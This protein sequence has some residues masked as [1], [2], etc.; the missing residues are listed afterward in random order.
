M[1]ISIAIDG[2]E[3]CNG[4][5]QVEDEIQAIVDGLR[6]ENAA[7]RAEL[8]ADRCTIKALRDQLKMYCEY[9]LSIMQS[10]AR[11]ALEPKPNNE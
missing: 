3:Y 8:K 11:A 10:R 4:A 5:S 1:I 7:L 6:A 2:K 9:N